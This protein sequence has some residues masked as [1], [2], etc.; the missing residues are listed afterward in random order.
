MEEREREREDDSRAASKRAK[1]SPSK[2]RMTKRPEHCV[3]RALDAQ[4]SSQNLQI[5]PKWSQFWT[6][7]HGL[8]HMTSQC[9]DLDSWRSSFSLSGSPLSIPFLAFETRVTLLSNRA[10][11]GSSIHSALLWFTSLCPRF[12]WRFKT[13]SSLRCLPRRCHDD[14]A[15]PNH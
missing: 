6:T 9:Q 4:A 3:M 1:S 8:I 5:P 13:S 7:F 15:L 10:L 12:F 2:K 11:L 14:S